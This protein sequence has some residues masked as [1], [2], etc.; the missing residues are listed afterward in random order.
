[1]S[2]PATIRPIRTTTPPLPHAL[3]DAEILAGQLVHTLR[4]IK[5]YGHLEW[6]AA[7]GLD[8]ALEAAIDAQHRITTLQMMEGR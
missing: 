2:A 5:E 6:F 1:M 8:D 7:R 4:Q 3:V